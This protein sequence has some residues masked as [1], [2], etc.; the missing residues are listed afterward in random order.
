VSRPSLNSVTSGKLINGWEKISCI[1]S[2]AS[3]AENHGL[4]SISLRNVEARTRIETLE[5][6]QEILG[7]VQRSGT[8]R[9]ETKNEEISRERTR[10]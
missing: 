2:N 7:P 1:T 9:N 4:C 5:R 6:L 3:R 10:N 8:I